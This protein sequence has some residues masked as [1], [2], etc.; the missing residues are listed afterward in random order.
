MIDAAQLV[1]LLG[2]PL[3]AVE[4][5]NEELYLD[6]AYERLE[7]MICSTVDSIAE[8]RT[9]DGRGGYSTVFTDFFVEVSSVAVDGVTLDPADYSVRQWNKR[10]AAWYNS[11]VLDNKLCVDSEVVIDAIWG[12]GE[13]E[14]DNITMPADLQLLIAKLF[15]LVSSMN[16][17][18]GNVKSKK[19]EDF[20][21]TYNENS[22][23][24]QFVIDNA[25]TIRKYSM[26]DVGKTRHGKIRNAYWRLEE[27]WSR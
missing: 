4:T 11:I 26:C 16:K 23:Y 22:V 3:T 19:I 20:S 7:W 24:T 17:G 15:A 12:F 14:D 6:I 1:K 13:S 25:A 27:Y 9:Y 10:N 18:N 2:R 5:A 8:E 21:I